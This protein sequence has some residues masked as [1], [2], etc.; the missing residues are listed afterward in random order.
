[1][2]TSALSA[3]ISQVACYSGN[4]KLIH[5]ALHIQ[6]NDILP[7]PR[8]GSPRHRNHVTWAADPRRGMPVS[9]IPDNMTSD[10]QM[11]QN[12]SKLTS[13]L[14]VETHLPTL[15]DTVLRLEVSHFPLSNSLDPCYIN[16][17]EKIFPPQFFHECGKGFRPGNKK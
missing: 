1:M 8:A 5:T 10:I 2:T 16:S 9:A 7:R 6:L 13:G 3:T 12:V 11:F 4:G 15:A 17:Y 14:L